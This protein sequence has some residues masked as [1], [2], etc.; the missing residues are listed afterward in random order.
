MGPSQLNRNLSYCEV[1]RQKKK[2]FGAS[3]GFELV[4]SAFTLQC[5]TSWAMKTHTL[6]AGQFIE[7][8]NPWKDWN[9]EWNDVNCR[10]TNEMNMWPSQLNSNLSTCEVARKKEFSGLQWDLN[11]WPLPSR[12]S[13]LPAELWRPMHW[14]QANLLSSSTHERNETQNEMVWT[15]GIQMKWI[16]DHHS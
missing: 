5:S 8:I 3:T 11:P 9:T 13:A 12:C 16:C 2:F 10:N 1:A 6:E 14:R 4:A 15:A 7:F